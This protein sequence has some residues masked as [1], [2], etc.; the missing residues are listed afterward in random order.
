MKILVAGATGSI[1]FHIVNTTIK[2]VHHPVALVRTIRKV[3]LL[4]LERFIFTVMF[5]CL[6]D[7]SN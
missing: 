4:L 1:D 7:S 2:M 6:K 3:K 5:Q